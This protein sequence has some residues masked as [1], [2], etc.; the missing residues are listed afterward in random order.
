MPLNVVKSA[1][2]RAARTFVQ[3]FLAGLAAGVLG[4]VDL[5]TARA[6]VLSVG[7]AALAAAWR[8]IDTVPVP[9]LVDR[10]ATAGVP[11]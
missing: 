8:A 3:T 6:L 11:T 4:V 2:V 1:A 5:P 9:T 7:A 10:H